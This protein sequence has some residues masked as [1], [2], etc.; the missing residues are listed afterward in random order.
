VGNRG[1]Y[2]DNP[3][4][5]PV[6]RAAAIM[7]SYF[8]GL[9]QVTSVKDLW[10]TQT[11]TWKT[12]DVKLERTRGIPE[13]VNNAIKLLLQE[14]QKAK[15]I[16]KDISKDFTNW[17]W[18][19]LEGKVINISSSKVYHIMLKSEPDLENINRWWNLQYT[20]LLWKAQWILIWNTDIALKGRTFIWR[21]IANGLFTNERASK[22]KQGTGQCNYCNEAIE[23]IPHLFFLCPFAQQI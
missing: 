12:F 5:L 16:S 1:C 21:I 18:R 23:S 8:F 3:I 11:N 2:E 10:D 17:K 19:T 7:N 9:I 15:G 14:F 22:L 13:W 4:N 6:H 20:L